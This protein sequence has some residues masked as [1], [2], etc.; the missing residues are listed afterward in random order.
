MHKMPVPSVVCT[1]HDMLKSTSCV[2]LDHLPHN[3]EFALCGFHMLGLKKVLRAQQLSMDKKN[4]VV[5][6]WLQQY[7]PREF[8]MEGSIIWCISGIA[9]TMPVEAIVNGLFSL[10][11]NN[12]QIGFI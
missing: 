8:S 10:I 11:Q 4:G 3:P 1:V 2:V 5:V 12:I 7:Q 9:V 6:H